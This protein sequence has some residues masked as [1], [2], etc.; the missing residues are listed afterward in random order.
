MN[1]IDKNKLKKENNTN[2]IMKKIKDRTKNYNLKNLTN[3]KNSNKINKQI[4]FLKNNNL[5][6]KNKIKVN[7]NKMQ[8]R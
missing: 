5:N 3:K 1:Q 4:K 8:Q 2:K 6:H 7:Y